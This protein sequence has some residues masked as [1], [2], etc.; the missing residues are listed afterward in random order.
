VTV[1]I[2]ERTRRSTVVQA[3]LWASVGLAAC[4]GDSPTDFGDIGS[5]GGT[6]VDLFPLTGTSPFP[7]VDDSFIE[8]A[9]AAGF[10]FSFYGV[11]YSSVFLNTNGGMTFGAGLGDYDVAAAD[12]ASPGIAVFWGD[13][14]A[15]EATRANQMKYEVC[16]D[17]FIVRYVAM[18]DNDVDTANNTATIML[19]ENGKI[20]VQ[21]GAVLS[22]DILA[23][24]WDGTHVGDDYV[25]VANSYSGYTTSGSGTILFDDWGPGPIHTGQLTGRTI[26]YNP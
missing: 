7:A 26:V 6:V 18:Q 5:C 23:G 20:T 1:R 15:G 10:D 8:V 22:E 25:S 12:V 3:V 13:L 21:Y 14:D 2:P 4:G 19:E 24:V 17:R 11:T 9:F 16:S